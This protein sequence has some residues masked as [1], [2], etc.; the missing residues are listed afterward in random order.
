MALRNCPHVLTRPSHPCVCLFAYLTG[1]HFASL[2]LRHWIVFLAILF[3]HCCPLAGYLSSCSQKICWY[4]GNKSKLIEWFFWGVPRYATRQDFYAIRPK[5]VRKQVESC[6]SPRLGGLKL[7]V[8]LVPWLVMDGFLQAMHVKSPRTWFV[9]AVS[10]YTE[11]GGWVVLE[12]FACFRA[13][14]VKDIGQRGFLSCLNLNN[15]NNGLP[16]QQATQSDFKL[17]QI[18]WNL[19]PPFLQVWVC[20]SQK[21]VLVSQLVL[22]LA[23]VRSFFSLDPSVDS[24]PWEFWAVFNVLSCNSRRLLPSREPTYPTLGKGKSSTQN[25]LFWGYVSS[26]EGTSVILRVFDFDS[27]KDTRIC[28]DSLFS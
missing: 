13:I 5:V 18:I 2:H 27:L 14:F 24:V 15:Y 21:P 17:I 4:V 9:Q 8:L 22:R 26:Q 23:Q 10:N 11:V 25:W 7:A 20:D 6:E 12:C 3:S 16:K 1:D 28:Q 19:F